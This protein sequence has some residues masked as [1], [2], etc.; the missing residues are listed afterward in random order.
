MLWLGLTLHGLLGALASQQVR[1]ETR[2]LRGQLWLSKQDYVKGCTAGPLSGIISVHMAVRQATP[3]A[4]W[5][6][7]TYNSTR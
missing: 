6:L 7:P 1:Q 2:N 5:A 4:G 3:S